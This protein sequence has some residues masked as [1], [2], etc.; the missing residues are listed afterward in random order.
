MALGPPDPQ[1]VL[2]VTP[3]RAPRMLL[4]RPRLASTR[5][6][7]ADKAVI[8]LQAA[9]GFGKTSLLAQWRKEA[10]QAAQ[11]GWLTLGGTPATAWWPGSPRPCAWAADARISA[12][13]V[14]VRPAWT[15]VRSRA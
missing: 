15:A 11:W 8:A 10:L 9:A 5:L 1:L 14:S 2:K 3:P 6:E 13:L 12:R 7:F 4:E